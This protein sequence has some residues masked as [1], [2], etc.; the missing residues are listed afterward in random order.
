MKAK[1]KG[2][3]KRNHACFTHT[4]RTALALAPLEV[5]SDVDSFARAEGLEKQKAIKNLTQSYRQGLVLC[6]TRA[7]LFC[8]RAQVVADGFR[9]QVSVSDV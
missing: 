7:A 4:G 6:N 8:G 2:N 1:A 9:L 5:N 3:A